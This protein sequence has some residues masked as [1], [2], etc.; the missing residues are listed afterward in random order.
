MAAENSERMGALMTIFKGCHKANIILTFPFGVAP[1]LGELKVIFQEAW[2]AGVVDIAV[3]LANSLSCEVFSFV[4]FKGDGVCYDTTPILLNSWKRHAK[5]AENVSK[6]CFPESKIYDLQSCELIMIH[7]N[8]NS[9]AV[10]ASAAEYVALF[11]NASVRP[12]LVA[13][14]DVHFPRKEGIKSVG[15]ATDIILSRM[16][17]TVDAAGLFAFS[18]FVEFTHI[19][20]VVPRRTIAAV[21]WSRLIT[22]FSWMLWC[23]IGVSFVASVA[24]FYVLFKGRKALFQIILYVLQLLLDQAWAGSIGKWHIRMYLLSW[25]LFSFVVTASYMCSLLSKLTVPLS[26]DSFKNIHEF[27]ESRLVIHVPADTKE[28]LE[29][30][31]FSNGPYELLIRQFRSVNKTYANVVD[32]HRQDIAYIINKDDFE[33]L[34]ANLPYRVLGDEPLMT[35]VTTPMVLPKPSPYERLFTAALL[36]A[37][38]C[39]VFLRLHRIF[40]ARVERAKWRRKRLLGGTRKPLSLKSLSVVFIIWLL[41]CAFASLAFIFECG[42]YHLY[43]I[44]VMFTGSN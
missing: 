25:V 26:E 3:V 39:G 41:G 2:N 1:Q 10:Y 35:R 23:G 30:Q 32:K 29:K 14:S 18:L 19:A 4:P 15:N 36:R 20:L 24:T 28:I 16:Y 31:I 7:F 37:E 12:V 5:Q 13:P 9:L 6:T 33:I 8:H 43:F 17:L 11:M 40:D 42:Y 27:L 38:A 22:E 44:S 34:F 21:Q